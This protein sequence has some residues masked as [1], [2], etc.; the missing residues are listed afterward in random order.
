MKFTVWQVTSCLWAV[1]LLYSVTEG[2]R[3]DWQAEKTSA[4]H[5]SCLTNATVTLDADSD[6]FSTSHSE[7]DFPSLILDDPGFS[8]FRSLEFFL[9]HDAFCGQPLTEVTLPRVA[10]SL[11]VKKAQLRQRLKVKQLQQGLKSIS[12]TDE[13]FLR[14]ELKMFA[15]AEDAH[16]APAVELHM[17]PSDMQN[18]KAPWRVL[19]IPRAKEVFGQRL[20]LCQQA[21]Q[22][23]PCIAELQFE[24]LPF[25]LQT[26][27][28]YW[29][30]Y[31]DTHRST[32]NS[33]LLLA[34]I[35][36]VTGVAAFATSVV[37]I[38]VIWWGLGHS[39]D[40]SDLAAEFLQAEYPK[41][42]RLIQ[43]ACPTPDADCKGG[44]QPLEAG[45]EVEVLEVKIDQRCSGL[46]AVACGD[47]EELLRRLRGRSGT[48]VWGRIESCDQQS[49][50]MLCD[51]DAG[52]VK[53]IESQVQLDA[54]YRALPILVPSYSTFIGETL[55]LLTSFLSSVWCVVETVGRVSALVLVLQLY[56]IHS[57]VLKQ[58]RD[59]VSLGLEYENLLQT[60]GMLLQLPERYTESRIVYCLMSSAVVQVALYV[61]G[62]WRAAL[63]FI[64]SFLVFVAL[65]VQAVRT[66]ISGLG[67]WRTPQMEVSEFH[68]FRTQQLERTLERPAKLSVDTARRW[69]AF[70]CVTVLFLFVGMMVPA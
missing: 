38:T 1:K 51:I 53:V 31:L 12:K 2:V 9:A 49:W 65:H 50:L 28:G 58:R 66:V 46:S 23:E 11:D 20:F 16:V 70:Q 55:V 25:R 36:L 29:D 33:V 64:V 43:H 26:W 52:L 22:Q 56:L 4:N 8:Y 67:C 27:F 6:W 62:Q 24:P 17:F 3:T 10:K 7:F 13:T 59:M 35:G 21:T 40:K 15:Q 30:S 19:L 57:F 18:L 41:Q 39:K 5:I 68:A 69:L 63:N 32:P 61:F 47:W 48:A 34:E 54:K 60:R 45:T 42:Y 14:Q 44:Q 37:V